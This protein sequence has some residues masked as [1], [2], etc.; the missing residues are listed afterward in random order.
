MAHPMATWRNAAPMPGLFT[1]FVDSL[2]GHLGIHSGFG[3]GA[4]AHD[5]SL[6]GGTGW[7]KP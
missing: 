5:P 6:L 3:V 7:C 4:A 2:R 1:G